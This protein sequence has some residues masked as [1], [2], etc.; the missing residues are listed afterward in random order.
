M[1]ITTMQEH[2]GQIQTLMDRWMKKAK[3]GPQV[4]KHPA[5]RWQRFLWSVDVQVRPADTPGYHAALR[6]RMADISWGGMAVRVEEELPLHALV[7]V[8]LLDEP[9]IIFG[10]VMS[11]RKEPGQALLVGIAFLNRG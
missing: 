9:G 7:Q 10:R 3:I 4:A 2:A 6:G 5:Q 8:E 11:L 1:S